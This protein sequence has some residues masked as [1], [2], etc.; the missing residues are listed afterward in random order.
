VSE[1]YPNLKDLPEG[2]V[3]MIAGVEVWKKG[4][5][6]SEEELDRRFSQVR[7]KLLGKLP[8]MYNELALTPPSTEPLPESGN[9]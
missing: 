2:S 9:K 4:Q 3:L 7:E 5:E 8:Q 1:V 6:I